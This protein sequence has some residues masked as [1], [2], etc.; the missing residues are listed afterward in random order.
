M[1]PLL[2][3][4]R[5]YAAEHQLSRQE[6]AARLEVPYSTVKGWLG[7]RPR[8]KLSRASEQRIQALLGGTLPLMKPAP[9]GEQAL[10][11]KGTQVDARL[12]VEAKRRAQKLKLL[13]LLLEDEMRWFRDGRP[14][15]RAAYRAALD[16]YDIGYISS[17]L[18]ML[19]DE[20]KFQRWKALTTHRFRSFRRRDKSVGA[21]SPDQVR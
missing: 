18:S 4:L 5:S 12:G 3:Q 2:E 13:L 7:P 6:I 17:L 16:P 10:A 1:H 9:R 14:E 8:A 20:E 11:A 19:T 21:K 15:S